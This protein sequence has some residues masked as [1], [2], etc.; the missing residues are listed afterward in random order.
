MAR[1]HHDQD[2]VRRYLLK[3]LSDAE[4][5]D[6]ALR[7]LSDDN[8]SI[9]LEIAEDELIDEYVTHELSRA[10][11]A[12]FEQDFLTTPERLS[13][14]KSAQTLKRYFDR[15][16]PA[17]QPKPGRFTF[18]PKW[19]ALSFLQ[20]PDSVAILSPRAA[21]A[22]TL[23]L[24]AVAGVIIWRVAFFKSDLQKGLMAL[25]DAYRKERPIEARVSTL[26]YAPF[27]LTRGDEPVP[28][29]SFELD[30]AR[31]FLSNAEKDR[32]DADS[33]HALGKLYLLQ[34]EYDRSIQY[35]ERAAKTDSKNPQIYADLGAAYLEK[36]QL[37]L[38]AS[39]SKEPNVQSGKGLADLGQ[40]LEYLKQALELDPN[41]LEAL[42]NR[43]LVHEQ[44]SLYQEAENDWRVYIEKDSSSQWAVDARQKL[45]SLEDRKSRAAQDTKQD[46]KIE[47]FMHA[48]LT[49]DNTTAWEIYRRSYTRSGNLL[50][51]T[52]VD[53][54]LDSEP[55]PRFDENLVALRDVGQL[56]T[57]NAKDSFTADL[58]H[59]YA[60]T[61]PQT[62]TLLLEARRQVNDGY[63]E[64]DES[65]F[66]KAAELF[67]A[68][69]KTFD[70]V[71]DHPESL[72]TAIP[73]AHVAALETHSEAEEVITKVVSDCKAKRYK[74]LLG[75]ALVK[76]A[77]IQS[78]LNEYSE[79]IDDSRQAL[80]IFQE[81]KDL[82]NT[83][84][85][86]GQL[87]SLHLS[88]NDYE[89]S[90]S[91]LNR[92]ITTAEE[93]GAPQTQLWGVYIAASVNLSALK[94]YR[95][96]L[97]YQQ[98]A[99]HLALSMKK[100][101]PISRS[102]E[103]IG[104]TYG[105]LRQ[106][107]LAFE[108]I[109]RAYDEGKRRAT[110]HDGKNMMAS[111]SLRLGD[112]YRVSGDLTNALAA[113]D[114]SSRLYKEMEF[115]HYT[116][117]SHKGKFL[118]YLAQNNDTLAEQELE[119]ILDLFEKYREKIVEDRQA[120]YF[121]DKEQDICDLAIDFTYFRLNDQHRAFDRAEIC[122]A[123]NLHRLIKHGAKVTP[124]ASGMDL[125]S[126]QPRESGNALP[127]TGA[128]IQ[129]QIPP[130]VQIVQYVV[131]E[132]RLLVWCI[133]NG[134]EPFTRFIEVDSSTLEDL[135]TTARN[136]I[137][138]RDDK[139]SADSLKRL[140]DLLIAPVSSRLDSSKVLCFIPDKK[141]HLLPFGALMSTTSGHYLAE[142]YW[143]MISS[144]STIL[145]ESSN[146]AQERSSVQ[147]E[148]L[149]AV[150]NPTF[151]RSSNPDLPNLASAER[152]AKEIARRY[153]PD[154]RVL[155]GPQ[156]TRT[157]VMDELPRAQVAH[158]AAH[159]QIDP[160]S[161]L[162]SKVLLS[163][164]PGDRAHAQPSALDS[165]DIYQMDLTRTRLVVL[166]ACQTGI[167]QQLRG[168]GPIGFARSFLVAGVPVVVASLWPV[169]SEATYE[170]MISFHRLR[171]LNHLPTTEALTRAQR[172]IMKREKYNHPYY[173][174]G[175]TAIGGYSEF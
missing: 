118:S 115:D 147:D 16:A 134:S 100:P 13:K 156:A 161:P 36:G 149:L 145:I 104:L 140:Y 35:L 41:L 18:L 68:A 165:A 107:D 102:Y 23:L 25:N 50:T 160:Q 61:T 75:Q 52:L 123:R 14:L 83:L 39:K 44:Q 66:P 151:D 74:W 157:S 38:D 47:T 152:E 114:E 96:A 29:N 12:R 137:K 70:Q 155:I 108:N 141:L 97:D 121:F 77:H 91:F 171:R 53:Q 71:G 49:F 117:P 60:S 113:Y 154:A 95:A 92:A 19:P 58:A 5:Q 175:F 122:R 31:Q 62:R 9:E 139:G 20:G 129:Q 164:E 172:E 30:R 101:R 57:R 51:N 81:L 48:L 144:S 11:R 80:Q 120:S 126:S 2:T 26:D 111:A 105:A 59:V 27:V 125:R 148:R 65:N 87:A 136:Q 24:V 94:L 173:W 78:N 158:F 106:F 133:T 150:G 34:K 90:F 159:Y 130:Q 64:F 33:A 127:L 169:D 166:S 56:E 138:Q 67:A 174:A 85:T 46:T 84:V 93:Q 43:G 22:M 88:L 72:A 42:F 40:S 37:E 116:Y 153:P 170:L 142:D 98:E 89:R 3:K 7:I 112:L 4:Q 119:I 79:A 54:L 10:D 6:V 28:V 63:K 128:E 17:P 132:K 76:R 32:A 109:R 15:V 55:G 135:V 163:P 110:E 99:L 103:N 86:F 146:R 45:K 162:S 82:T 143:L 124:G 21:M 168:E 8:F 167:E 73:A 1:Q 131:L 69:Q